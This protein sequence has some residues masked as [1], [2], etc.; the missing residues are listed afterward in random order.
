MSKPG[1]TILVNPNFIPKDKKAEKIKKVESD[2]EK[3][4]EF[5]K[6]A[7]EMKELERKRIELE[8]WKMRQEI[9]NMKRKLA[10]VSLI[11]GENFSLFQNS[12]IFQESRGLESGVSKTIESTSSST[13]VC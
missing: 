12:I 13:K 6:L 8:K 7:E 5:E 3:D 10:E 9:E 1:S 2:D 4:E 11:F